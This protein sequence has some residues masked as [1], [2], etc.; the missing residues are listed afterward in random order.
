LGRY[1]YKITPQISQ[2]EHGP[3]WNAA[4]KACRKLAPAELP[5]TEAR[6]QTERAKLLKVVAC[7]H[8]HG[9]PGM[10]DPIIRPDGISIAPPAGAD[11][12]SAQFQAAMRTCG[13]S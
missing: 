4:L 1:H 11:P 10:P 5:F 7:M 3:G 12:R 6:M 9:Y 8:A 13:F 2:Q